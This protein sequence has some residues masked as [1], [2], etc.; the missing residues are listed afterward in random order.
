MAQG[1]GGSRRASFEEGAYRPPVQNQFSTSSL[2]SIPQ[3]PFSSS[4]AP[5]TMPT[6][7]HAEI[8]R[9]GRLKKEIQ[10]RL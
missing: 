1:T 8:D 6:V 10:R 4:F 3:R 2:R 7:E 9:E 5:P